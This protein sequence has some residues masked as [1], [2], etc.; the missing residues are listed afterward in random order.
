MDMIAVPCVMVLRVYLCNRSPRQTQ[1][2]YPPI[3]VNH[4]CRFWRITER[5][6]HR[7]RRTPTDRHTR[8][9]AAMSSSANNGY[10]VVVDVDDEGD[11]GHTDLTDL[12]F[13]QSSMFLTVGS[14]RKRERSGAG[15]NCRDVGNGMK[16]TGRC[17]LHYNRP[18]CW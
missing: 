14:G 4:S 3:A 15:R 16:L 13:H 2:C 10:D 8:L 12:E 11:L 9:F 18:I 6:L 1:G 5:K 7:V 17:S